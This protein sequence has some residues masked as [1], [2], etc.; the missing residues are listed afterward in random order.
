M[1]DFEY[2][3]AWQRFGP[4]TSKLCV[5]HGPAAH[6]PARDLRDYAGDTPKPRLAAASP[7]LTEG[8]PHRLPLS[9][10]PDDR[11][12]LGWRRC[13]GCAPRHRYHHS[14]KHPEA[15]EAI[16]LQV[17]AVGLR[18]AM[19]QRLLEHEVVEEPCK[20]ALGPRNSFERAMADKRLEQTMRFFRRTKSPGC[21]MRRRSGC[22][23]WRPSQTPA[24]LALGT[25]SLCQAVRC[26]DMHLEN[27]AFWFCRTRSPGCGMRW[28]SGCSSWRPLWRPRSG[29][30]QSRP[31]KTCSWAHG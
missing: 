21:G 25:P 3:I 8:A 26:S 7:A 30:C 27:P 16:L 14:A 24:H 11:G 10:N 13:E 1:G 20:L 19:A 4:Q 28:R 5:S 17:E 23:S 2:D 15:C 9:L 18:A 12:D 6:A 22:S 29:S 31:A